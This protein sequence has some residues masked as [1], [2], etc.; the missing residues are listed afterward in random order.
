MMALELTRQLIGF[1]RHLSQHVG[2]FVI[3]RGA[4]SE[5]VPVVNAAM[6]D[7]TFV[8]WDKDDLDALGILKVDVLALGMLTCIAKSF[9]MFQQHYGLEYNLATVPVEDPRVYDMLCTGDSVGVFQVE[10]RAQM[11]MLPRLKPRCFYDLVIEVAIVRPGPIQGDMVHPYLR[12]RNGEEE[13]IFPSKELEEVL[14]KT[15]G[16]PLFQEQAMKIAI[17]AAGFTPSEADRLRRAMATFRKVGTIH[18]FGVKLIEG[19]VERGYEREFAERCFKQIEGFGEY[20]FPES[21]SASFSL[22]VYVSSWI[23]CHYPDIFCCALLNSQP[24]GF[25]AP[26]QLVRDARDH[27]VEVRAVDINFSDWDALLEGLEGVAKPTEEGGNGRAVRL[28]LRQIKGFKGASAETLMAARPRQGYDSVRDVWLR[29]GLSPRVLERL[30]QAD[31]FRSIGLDRRGA[32]W[33]VKA[34]GENPL[35]LFADP[36]SRGQEPEVNLPSMPLG[37]HVVHDYAHLRL[38]LKAHPLSFLR[39]RLTQR[40]VMPNGDL[41]NV[42]D[43]KRVIVSGLVLVRQRPGTASGVIFAT[44]EDESGVA[45][46]VIWP[47]V[48]EKYRRAILG[49]RV[50]GVRGRVQKEG[51]VIHVVAEHIEDL[52]GE[53]GILSSGHEEIEET[54][55]QTLAKGDAVKHPNRDPAEVAAINRQAREDRKAMILPKSRDFH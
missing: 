47:N 50:F 7:R 41:P 46:V 22:L 31:C 33:A 53:L 42:R 32:L 23:K 6:V 27:G 55:A 21:H 26:A 49:A 54:L 15:L 39:A 40:G 2:G 34:L 35:P 36:A 9:D 17:V 13:V 16:V 43:G 30:A 48:F 51:L 8:E 18:T 24:L 20:G 45:N 5:V 25:Y 38:S 28:G 37:E 10:S 1:P 14:G 3:T 29:S 12:R 44:L 11:T 4:L 52:T 19:M